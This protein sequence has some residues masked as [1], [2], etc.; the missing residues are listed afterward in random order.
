MVSKIQDWFSEYEEKVRIVGSSQWLDWIVSKLKDY[1]ALC[2]DDVAYDESWSQGDKDKFFLISTFH[3]KLI[4]ICKELNIPYEDEEACFETYETNFTYKEKPYY[5]FTMVGQGAVTS[6]MNGFE[7]L[8][9]FPPIT[10]DSYYSN[11]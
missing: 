9:K 4:S 6:I 7:D 3:N 10:I 1:P 5:I 8:D 11:N 2:D